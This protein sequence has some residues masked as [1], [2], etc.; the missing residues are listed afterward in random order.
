MGFRRASLALSLSLILTASATPQ[1]ISTSTQRDPQALAVLTQ[2]LNAIGGAAAVSG[3]QDFTGTG[4]IT[5]NWA[6]QAI[7]GSATVF[8]KGLNEFRMDTS[9]SGGTQSFV[10]NG[11]AGSL[12]LLKSPKTKLPFYSIMTSGSLT[13]PAARIANILS[14]STTGVSYLGSLTWNGSQVYR[15]H[16][17]PSPDPSLSFGATLPGLGEFDLYVDSASYQLVGL[18]EKVWW[19]NDLTQSYSHEI[20]FSNYTSTGGLSVPFVITEKFGGQ[21]TWS[22]TLNS[23]IFNSGLS[24]TLFIP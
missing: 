19:G 1:Q 8:G 3:I 10:V 17:T 9:V 2:C 6:D 23:L 11:N 4:T 7:P 18:A 22:I 21:Q 5:Y 16:V 15:V 12:T 14:N 13:F 24:D 20:T